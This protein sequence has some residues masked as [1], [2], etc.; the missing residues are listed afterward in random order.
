MRSQYL[1]PAVFLV[2]WLLSLLLSY[3]R[4]RAQREVQPGVDPQAPP[5][6]SREATLQSPGVMA[7]RVTP[8]PSVVPLVATQPRS[9]LRL[10]SPQDVRRG[11]VLITILGPCR[12]LKPPELLE[13]SDG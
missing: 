2:G 9:L 5:V 12:A 10:H 13:G 1:V 6:L 11:M 8:I 3:L 4:Q 7:P